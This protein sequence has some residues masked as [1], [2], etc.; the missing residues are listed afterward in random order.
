MLLGAASMTALVALA[1]PAAGQPGAPQPI[2]SPEELAC[3]PAL[4]WG[5][6]PR[7]IV[8]LGS[9][10]GGAKDM[11]GPSDALVVGAGRNRGVDVGQRYF[12]RRVQRPLTGLTMRRPLPLVRRT[13]GW[14]RIVAVE[15]RA[16]IATVEY[17]CDGMLRGDYLEP[18]E[19]PAVPEADPPGGEPDYEAAG[20]VLFG[21]NGSATAGPGQ[22]VVLSRGSRNGL[23]A[24]QRL[25]LFRRSFG[26]E[27]PVAE[28]GEAVI[29]ALTAE[30]SVARI[31]RAR[32]A[33]MAGDLAAPHR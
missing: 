4:A 28:V 3:A 27:G 20:T 13:A 14:I 29:V 19:L 1:P 32:D 31:L 17:A 25:T 30:A 22:F 16:A 2:A 8:L 10:E 9:Q 24:G 15:E 21:P 26:P 6:P 18:F 7:P 5:P 12:V 23:H 33:T 11:M